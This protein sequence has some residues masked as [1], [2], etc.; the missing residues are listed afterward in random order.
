MPFGL[1]IAGLT[2]QHPMKM[3]FH[4]QIRKIVECYVDDIVVKR[5]DK[6]DYIA[7]LKRVFDIMLMHS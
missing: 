3:I 5:R 2:Y 7:N 1:K 6:G 4:K